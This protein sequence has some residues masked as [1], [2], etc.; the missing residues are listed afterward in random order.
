MNLLRRSRYRAKATLFSRLVLLWLT[1]G[2]EPCLAYGDRFSSIKFPEIIRG[3]IINISN[4]S[5]VNSRRTYF[6]L[7]LHITNIWV[8]LL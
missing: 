5:G 3:Y 1:V 7:S 8:I 4:W 2:I 6:L